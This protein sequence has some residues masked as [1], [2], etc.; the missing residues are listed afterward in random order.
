[1]DELVHADVVAQ[2]A[3]KF[4]KFSVQKSSAITIDQIMMKAD[5]VGRVH[6]LS[7]LIGLI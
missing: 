1:M 5:V 2:A 6:L 7:P 4:S 3:Y